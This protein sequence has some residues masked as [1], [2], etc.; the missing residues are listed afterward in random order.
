MPFSLAQAQ[1]Y[2]ILNGGHHIQVLNQTELGPDRY[3]LTIV[4][5]WLGHY[6]IR[7]YLVLRHA[8]EWVTLQ[9]PNAWIEETAKLLRPLL[10]ESNPKR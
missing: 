10:P 3:A 6:Q 2:R 8:G 4:G 1:L 5:E 9:V 7:C